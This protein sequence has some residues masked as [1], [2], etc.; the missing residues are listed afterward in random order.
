MSEMDDTIIIRQM[1]KVSGFIR[2][3]KMTDELLAMIAR[4]NEMR[5]SP[6]MVKAWLMCGLE[7]YTHFSKWELVEE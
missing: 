6:G 1:D 2:M 4:S 7:V 3:H 5:T